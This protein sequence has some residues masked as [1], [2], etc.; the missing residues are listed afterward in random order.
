MLASVI[1]NCADKNVE[2]KINSKVILM[3]TGFWLIKIE[4][5][6]YLYLNVTITS[7][8]STALMLNSMLLQMY[9]RSIS[10]LYNLD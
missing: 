10:A 3:N 4:S 5:L 2:I 9:R 6:S 8:M 1:V 7:F